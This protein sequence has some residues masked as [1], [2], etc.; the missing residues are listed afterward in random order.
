[1]FITPFLITN[2]IMFQGKN[3]L[4]SVERMQKQQ[5]KSNVCIVHRI[6]RQNCFDSK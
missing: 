4:G 6:I 1:M 5:L 2:G 3:Q